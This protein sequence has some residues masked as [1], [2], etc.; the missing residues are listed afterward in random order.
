MEADRYAGAVRAQYE[1]FTSGLTA[2]HLTISA[3]GRDAKGVSEFRREGLVAI[4]TLL[5]SVT[6]LTES[7][8]TD[9]GRPTVIY[10]ACDDKWLNQLRNIA[11]K[12]MNDLIVKMMGG[13]LRPADVLNRPGG[14]VGLLLQKKLDMPRLTVCDR[15]GRA[16]PADRMVATSARDFAYQAYLDITIDRLDADDVEFVDVVYPDPTHENHGMTIRLDEVGLI[17]KTIFHPNSSARL[18]PH[19]Q[20]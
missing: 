8:L 2:R 13:G 14:A 18:V 11:I 9:L 4:T 17:R 19:V 6:A 12:N 1:L 16:R 3:A 20:A 7:Y 5:A 15:A 10:D